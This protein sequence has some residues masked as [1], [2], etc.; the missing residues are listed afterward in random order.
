[1][2][3]NKKYRTF[4]LLAVSCLLVLPVVAQDTCLRTAVGK[5]HKLPYS[6][7]AL[8]AKYVGVALSDPGWYNWCNSPIKGKDGKIHMFGSRWPAA[9]GMEGWT[10][11]NA[12]VAHFVGDRPEG[13]FSYVST[14]MKTAMFPDPKTMSAPHNPRIEYVDGKYILLYICQNPTGDN[15]MR[16]GMMIADNIYGPWRYAGNNG[17]IMVE[18]SRDPKHWTYKAAIGADNPAFMKIGKKYYIYYKCGTPEHMKAKYGYAVSD[19]LEGPYTMCDAPISDN[20]SYIE[21][22]QVFKTGGK[23]Y[24]LTT[25]NLGGNTGIYGDIILWESTTGLEFKLANAKIAMGN[26]FDYWKTLDDRDK[27]LKQPGYFVRDHSGKLERPA[28]LLEKGKPTYFYAAGDVNI[29][30]G[31]VSE[32]YVFKI[33]WK[34]GKGKKKK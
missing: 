24:M 19:K 13:P 17:G 11:P 4:A 6:H 27:L 22:A 18:A 28:V 8:T 10:G 15:G 31:K 16:T 7:M 29:N 34:E 2:K 33:E 9:E 12:E 20:V 23:Y 21:D 32:T 5:Q 3:I 14:I 30:G 25:D 26:I 1:M